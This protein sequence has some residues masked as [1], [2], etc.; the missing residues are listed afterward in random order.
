ME[1]NVGYSQSRA[2]CDI[3]FDSVF[4]TNLNHWGTVFLQNLLVTEILTFPAQGLLPFLHDQQLRLAPIHLNSV[5]SLTLHSLLKILFNI[6]LLFT[7]SLRL[8]NG[9][10][11]RVSNNVPLLMC[12]TGSAHLILLDLA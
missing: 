4:E 9:L 2:D 5:H 12:A 3:T 1:A 6:I 11:R 8:S 7:P 10:F